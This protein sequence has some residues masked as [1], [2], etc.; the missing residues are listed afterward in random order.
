[1]SPTLGRRLCR[2][3]LAALLVAIGFDSGR[4]G[5]RKGAS[6]PT[7]TAKKIRVSEFLKELY[8][9]FSQD[10]VLAIAAGV[11][12]YALL[13][14]LP[15]IAALVSIYGIFADARTIH[16]TIA[17]MG[18]MMPGGAIQVIGDQIKH[19]VSARH[20][21]LG[22][23]ALGGILVSLWS[24]NSGVKAMFDALNIVLRE[25]EKRSFIR[26]NATSLAFTLGGLVLALFA[27]AVVV[28]LPAFL[29]KLGWSIPHDAINICRWPVVWVCI[30]IAIALLYRFGPSRNN[31]SWRWIS[32]GS[33]LASLVWLGASM[34]FS[35]YA[36]N[37]GTYNRTYG[38][39]GAVIGFMTWIWISAVIVLVGEELDELVEKTQ[40]PRAPS[41]KPHPLAASGRAQG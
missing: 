22:L 27:A 5:N 15:A 6:A 19:V 38:S 40:R 3:A 14:I 36:A 13:A 39:L 4:A 25:E 31:I 34:G 29:R 17:S 33:A 12:F 41:D 7:N 28:A 35:W 18:S 16:S 24:A 30:A 11:T 2:A 8:Q 26:L 1:M 23:A 20:S 32:W 21:A 10:R 37:F 9:H